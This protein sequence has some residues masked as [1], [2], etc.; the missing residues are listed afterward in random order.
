MFPVHRQVALADMQISAADSADYDLDQQLAG[1]RSRHGLLHVPQRAGLDR[2]WLA[3]RPRPH[4]FRAASSHVLHLSR[5]SQP[6]LR[7]GDAAPAPVGL[8][9]AIGQ[10]TCVLANWG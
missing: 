5:A 2:P 8:E 9:Y 7:I 4:R 6:A 1:S 3:H 10:M